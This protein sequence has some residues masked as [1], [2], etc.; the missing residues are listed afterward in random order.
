VQLVIL[1]A[2]VSSVVYCREKERAFWIGFLV[3]YAVTINRH[4]VEHLDGIGPTLDWLDRAQSKNRLIYGANVTLH[5][6]FKLIL[7]AIGGY[8]SMV[9]Y[10]RNRR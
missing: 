9:I 5:L 10:R 7:G 6:V 1:V 3:A 2:L 8:V 4:L